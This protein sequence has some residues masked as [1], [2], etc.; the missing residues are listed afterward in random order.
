[1]DTAVLVVGVFAAFLVEAALGFGS[2]VLAVSIGLFVVPLATLLPAFVPLNVALSL[3]LV[4]RYRRA[5]AWRLL[6]WRITPLMV[7][8][9]PLGMYGFA[10]GDERLL[11]LLFGAFVALLAGVE[12]LRAFFARRAAPAP[13]RPLPQVGAAALLLLGGMVHGAFATGGPLVVYVASRELPEKGAFRATLSALWLLLNAV[14]LGGY[15]V[16]GEFG[17]P[18][19]Q[20]AGLLTPALLAGLVVGEWVH[21]R[22]RGARFQLGVFGL[23]LVTGLVRVA[24]A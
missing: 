22:I 11:A 17:L 4:V 7:A 1:M 14:L 12:L 5:I 19:L 24:T 21:R 9:M 20:L 13:P 8:G 18:S 3:Y 16:R 10:H 2:T 23:L 6:A 15:V